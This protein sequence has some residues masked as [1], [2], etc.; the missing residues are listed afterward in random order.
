M[1]DALV[2]LVGEPFEPGRRRRRDTSA[3]A[4]APGV[5]RR[6]GRARPRAR[7]DM[8]A[9]HR[10]RPAAGEPIEEGL[11]LGPLVL[12]QLLEPQ[13]RHH[14]RPSTHCATPRTRTRDVA[15]GPAGVARH[16]RRQRG[17]LVETVAGQRGRARGE[18]NERRLI[19]GRERAHR[20]DQR[21]VVE[22][23]ARLGPRLVHDQRARG[24][25]AQ[26]LAVGPEQQADDGGGVA[27]RKEIGDA[28]QVARHRRGGRDRQAVVHHDL[29]AEHPL[30]RRGA[31]RGQLEHDRIEPLEHEQQNDP[32]RH[33]DA[34]EDGG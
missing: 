12:V 34:A 5:R 7:R 26:P 32:E 14:R 22:H 21:H 2:G 4:P 18:R 9:G 30:A 8:A 3:H 29:Q 23:R 1:V 15:S 24:Q 33:A 13:R 16:R 27:E 10:V 6:A 28:Q 17:E 19:L 25:V 11:E 31:R 20:R